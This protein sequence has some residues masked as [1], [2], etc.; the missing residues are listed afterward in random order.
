M[1]EF[2]IR[3]NESFCSWYAACAEWNPSGS[4]IL[5]VNVFSWGRIEYYYDIVDEM[6]PGY[7]YWLYCHQPCEV[8]VEPIISS[9]DT[10]VTEL[11]PGWNLLSNDYIISLEKQYLLVEYNATLYDW[12]NATSS[13]NPTGSPLLDITMFGWDSTMQIYSL[14]DELVPGQ[15]YWSYAYQNCKI[16]RRIW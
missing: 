4:S 15:G 9:Y 6:N 10:F 1:D 14:S 2:I 3:I 13:N 16:I 5:D 12:S 8:W 11:Q 7:A